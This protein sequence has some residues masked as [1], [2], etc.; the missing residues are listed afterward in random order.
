MFDDQ[1]EP[2]PAPAVAVSATEPVPV[3]PEPQEAVPTSGTALC[4]SGGGYRA[5]LFHVGVLWRLDEGGLLPELDRVSSVSGGSITAG[6]LGLNWDRLDFDPSGVAQGFSAQVVEPVRR[7]ARVGV[8]V[9]RCSP[10]SGCRSS[11]AQT[12]SP[13]RTAST[14]T[15]RPR[16]RIC[17]AARVS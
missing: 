3:T 17:P 1:Q 12:G 13:R 5:M 15:G 6:V 4:L 8:D 10:V 2:L 11:P 16:S 14:C 7:F 9:R